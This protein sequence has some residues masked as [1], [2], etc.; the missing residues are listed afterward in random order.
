MQD[1][2]GTD[3]TQEH[4]LNRADYTAPTRH[5]ESYHTKIGKKSA[6]KYL[7]HKVELDYMFDHMFE[8]RKAVN[9]RVRFWDK[10]LGISVEG[11]LQLSKG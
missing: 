5:H 9:I 11:F 3:L 6:L 8:V 1:L 10:L 4:V 7:D 2:H